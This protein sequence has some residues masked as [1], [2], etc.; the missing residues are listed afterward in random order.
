MDVKVLN[1]DYLYLDNITMEEYTKIKLEFTKELSNAYILKKRCPSIDTREEFMRETTISVGLW[2]E[3]VNAIKKYNI[4][5]NFCPEFNDIIYDS[6]ITLDAFSEYVNKLFKNAPKIKPKHYQ[7][8]GVYNILKYRRCCVEVSTNGGKTLMCYLLFKYLKDVLGLK[9]ILYITPNTNLT[10]QSSGKFSDYDKECG[11]V[12]DWTFDE[13]H[14]KAKKKDVYDSDI[15]FGNYQSLVKKPNSFFKMFDIVIVDECHHTV[16]KSITS[17]L[18]R[19]DN[20]KYKIGLTGTFPK[21]PHDSFFIQ[22]VLG[23]MVYQLTAY[24]L[25]N[26]EKFS[27]P[28]HVTGLILNYMSEKDKKELYDRRCAMPKGDTKIGGQLLDEERAIA[29]RSDKRF[30]YI[31]TM[32]KRSTKNTLIIF[33]DVKTEYGKRVYTELKDY[34]DKYV[35]YID[36]DTDTIKRDYA[37]QCMEDDTTGNTIIVASIGCFS[38]GIDISNLWNILLIETT[39]SDT[40]ISQLLGRGMRRFPGKEKTM[41]ID[42]GDDYCYGG[43]PKNDNY[44]MK[45]FNERAKIYMQRKFP[46]RQVEID[47]TEQRS[48][49]LF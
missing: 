19:C 38:E 4:N 7:I 24:D 20:A 41:F 40:S 49:S 23:P 21:D 17:I 29:R 9:H 36:G 32:A 8:E 10:T 1:K 27:T 39:K 16:A 44:L 18:Y 22:N 45:H 48:A 14:G 33:T 3:L 35:Y 11:I 31:C 26:I 28:V 6:T 25:I 13:I 46:Y 47:L 2:L 37:K 34:S 42:I 5:A 30:D 15:I 43:G 12:S